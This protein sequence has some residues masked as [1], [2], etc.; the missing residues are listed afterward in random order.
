MIIELRKI[1]VANG[2]VSEL[3][4]EATI[5]LEL[6][7]TITN[8]VIYRDGVVCSDSIC[9]IE[10]FEDNTIVFTVT[11]F[12]TYEVVNEDAKSQ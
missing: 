9:T 4:D 7:N 3:N 12:S 6:D 1:K 5:T 10:S 8:P 11:G 2:Y